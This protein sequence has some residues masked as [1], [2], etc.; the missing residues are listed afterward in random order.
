MEIGEVIGLGL[1]WFSDLEV[2]EIISGLI[3]G[4]IIAGCGDRWEW[5][6]K[7]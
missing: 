7:I 3:C 1:Y 6:D 5:L 2:R 4:L